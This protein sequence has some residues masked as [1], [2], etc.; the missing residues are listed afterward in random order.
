MKAII[1][2][3]GIGERL[4]PITYDIPKPLLPIKGRPLLEHLLIFLRKYDVKDIIVS[5]GYKADMIMQYFGNGEALG[6]NISYIVEKERLGT[7][8]CLNL[9]KEQPLETFIV[10]NGDDLTNFNL[11][12]MI[13]CHKKKGKKATLALLEVDDPSSYGVAKIKNG[14]IEEFVEKPKKE[15]APSN[16]IN[17]GFYLLEPDTLKLVRGKTKVMLEQDVFPVLAKEKELAYFKISTPWFDIG[18]PERYEEAI[19][20]WD[21][22]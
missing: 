6:L 17:S 20:S 8:G 4:R 7:G 10:M 16:L 1:L 3:G 21:G 13:S 18:T 19:K 12:E 15:E 9:L 14:L 11:K 2:A 5:V 22:I